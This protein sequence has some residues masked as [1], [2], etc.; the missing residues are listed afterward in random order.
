MDRRNFILKL[1]VAAAAAGLPARLLADSGLAYR[2]AQAETLSTPQLALSGRI[3]AR[4]RGTLFRNGPARHDLGGRRYRHWFDGDGMIQAF[5]FSDSGVSHVGK[6]V[7][8]AKFA[9]ETAAGRFLYSAFGTRFD[10]ARAPGSPDEVNAANTSVLP[11]AGE[12]LALWEGGSAYQLDPASLATVGPKV[13]RSDL[14]GMPFSAHPRVEPDGTLWN[15][16]VVNGRGLVL[17][18]VSPGGQLVKAD[19]VPVDA[20]P[21]VHDFAITERSLVFLLPP[22]VLDPEKSAAGASFLDSHVWNPQQPMRVL[23]LDKS[24]WSKRRWYE[25]PAGFLFHLGNAWEDETG[26]I[27]LDYMRYADPSDMFQ[28]FRNV[29]QGAQVYSEG[30]RPTL[31]KLDPARGALQESRGEHGE[32]P[33]IDARATGRRYSQLYSL[34]SSTGLQGIQRLDL[35]TGN[36]DRFDYG[37]GFVREEHIHVPDPASPRE[38]SGWLLGTAIDLKRRVTVL[39]VFEASNLAAGPMARASLPYALPAGFHGN[40][41]PAF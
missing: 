32:F 4:L 16:G 1:S 27:R 3:P 29:M 24:N 34:C 40:Y 5:R 2:S 21:M 11:F 41:L 30:A 17:Y 36:T 28:S 14:K 23:V 19:L 25:L 8:T 35:D 20:V 22:L 38:G 12:L 7:R 13:W 10:D 15:F 9:A 31:V 18:Q 33:R 39:S 37:S 26:V 6:F